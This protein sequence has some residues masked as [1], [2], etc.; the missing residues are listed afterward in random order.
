MVQN[1]DDLSASTG[2]EAVPDAVSGPGG[3]VAADN[4]WFAVGTERHCLRE[5]TNA[6]VI[7]SMAWRA[8]EGSKSG[9]SRRMGGL[10]EIAR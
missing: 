4:A 3:R 6:H 1:R 10:S 2:F 9:S 7:F 8:L 5:A